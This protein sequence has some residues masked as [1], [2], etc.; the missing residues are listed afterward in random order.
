[1]DGPGILEALLVGLVILGVSIPVSAFLMLTSINKPQWVCLVSITLLLL[2]A[3]LSF[4]ILSG[5]GNLYLESVCGVHHWTSNECRWHR[6]SVN[7][8]NFFWMPILIQTVC[9]IALLLKCDVI[10]PL[11]MAIGLVIMAIANLWVFGF[12]FSH[13]Y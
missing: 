2:L 13:G 7:K 8:V 10:R 5:L 4:F 6:Q 1:M 11:R 9:T 3:P 12:L